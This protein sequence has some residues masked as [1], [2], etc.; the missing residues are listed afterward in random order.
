MIRV[1]IDTGGDLPQTMITRYRIVE[2]PI[3]IRF[4]QEEYLEN[5]TIDEATF[6]EMV[7]VRQEIPQTSQPTPHQFRQIYDQIFEENSDARGN[8]IQT[9]DTAPTMPRAVPG[10]MSVNKDIT[11]FP[12]AIQSGKN[13]ACG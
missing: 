8:S 10:S 13:G 4:G 5:V 3:N 12:S 1:V 9:D 7:E 2:V 11:S 6:Y